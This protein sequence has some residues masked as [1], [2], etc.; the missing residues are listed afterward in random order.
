MSGATTSLDA[1]PVTPEMVAHA[2]ANPDQPLYVIDPEMDPD[3]EV[4]GWAIRG[5][6]T[7]SQAGEVDQDGWTPNP[8]YRPGPTT[9]GFPRPR[10][11]VERALQL[12]VAGY[13][14]N[15][16]L[17]AALARAHVVIPTALEHPAEVPVIAD[18]D[19]HNTVVIFTAEEY[20]S[21]ETPQ[22]TL[23][24]KNLR[25]LLS[26]VTIVLNPGRVP[27]ARIPGAALAAAII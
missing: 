22:L 17:L 18:H 21:G 9:L 5:Y 13:Q 2:R 16:I 15:A 12:V 7:V 3:G 4:P 6:Y 1:A 11:Q 23:P 24:V 19:G 8:N 14:P 26:T 25:P 20:L 10:N 27:S